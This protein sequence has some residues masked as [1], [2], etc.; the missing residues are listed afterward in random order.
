MRS[1]LQLACQPVSRRVQPIRA[2][3][4]ATGSSSF[5]GSNSN[6]FGFTCSAACTPPASFDNATIRTRSTG[7]TKLHNASNPLG[8]A[9]LETRGNVLFNTILFFLT[10]R[11]CRLS[12]RTTE[13]VTWYRLACV[14]MLMR[15]HKST[16]SGQV[17]AETVAADAYTFC[18]WLQT[19]A[20]GLGCRHPGR[21]IRKFEL[22][23]DVFGRPA[24]RC[25]NQVTTKTAFQSRSGGTLGKR[26]R[27]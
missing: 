10:A 4:S 14:H 9:H 25:L 15:E 17:N 3:T 5:E 13:A 22:R 27:A 24:P 1:L 20:P 16:T 2:D 19:A 21:A 26:S 18:H 7:L 8:I 12:N 11:Q 23:A 6:K